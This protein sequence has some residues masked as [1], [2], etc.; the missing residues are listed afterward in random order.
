M[1]VCNHEDS[2]K[3]YESSCGDNACIDSIYT[4]NS[5][6][7]G[8]VSRDSLPY[9]T[10]MLDTGYYTAEIIRKN[11]FNKY[12]I[13]DIKSYDSNT[14]VSVVHR[15]FYEYHKD[16][17]EPQVIGFSNTGTEYTDYT[18]NEHIFYLHSWRIGHTQYPPVFGGISDNYQANLFLSNFNRGIYR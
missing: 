11:G 12:Y 3:E 9:I 18:K 6:I 13:S 8:T 1:K 10:L 2:Q 15:F 4:V 17:S 5:V 14:F 16:N 7:C